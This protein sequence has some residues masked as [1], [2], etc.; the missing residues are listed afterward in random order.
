M[1]NPDFALLVNELAEVSG[2]AH[3]NAQVLWS[4]TT[5]TANQFG[6]FRVTVPRDNG[7]GFIFRSP[8]TTGAVG[9]HYEVHLTGS[10]VRWEYVL[11]NA[12]GDRPD[13]CTLSSSL[14]NGDWFGAT[15]TGTGNDTVVKVFVSATELDPDPNNWPSPACSMTGDPATPVDTGNRVGVRSWTSS[16]TADSSMDDVCVGGTPA[17]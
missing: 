6:R 9:P 2:D 11:D 15:I 4:G 16:D 14:Q 17:P 5:T 3:Q 12:F 8:A 7:Q 13:S 1:K 10:D